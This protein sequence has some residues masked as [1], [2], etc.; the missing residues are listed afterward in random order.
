VVLK[1]LELEELLCNINMFDNWLKGL[2][3]I[4]TYKYWKTELKKYN[5]RVIKFWKDAY[6]DI[7]SKNKED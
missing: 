5:D 2:E 7:T 4:Y 1:K 3:E 6:N